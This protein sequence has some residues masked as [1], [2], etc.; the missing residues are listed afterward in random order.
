MDGCWDAATAAAEW[1]QSRV[2]LF[3]DK[4]PKSSLSLSLGTR[5]YLFFPG[6]V[7]GFLVDKLCR[8]FHPET[9][10]LASSGEGWAEDRLGN[11]SAIDGFS[12]WLAGSKDHHWIEKQL[13]MFEEDFRGE[14]TEGQ[15]QKQEGKRC[16]CLEDDV[17]GRNE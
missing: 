4:S 5:I 2:S 15:R 17:G 16:I 1:V 10:G 3:E 9:A 6:Q 13:S 8:A 14:E 12:C 7:K 11:S